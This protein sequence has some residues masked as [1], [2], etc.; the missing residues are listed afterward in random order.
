MQALFIY[1]AARVHLCQLKA[2]KNLLQQS[3]QK[4]YPTIRG[5]LG[6][7]QRIAQ[8][9]VSKTEHLSMV[10]AQ[11]RTHQLPILAPSQFEPSASSTEWLTTVNRTLKANYSE[12]L[13]T[14]IFIFCYKALTLVYLQFVC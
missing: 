5:L 4:I 14:F 10:V 6:Q 7:F 9:Q 12:F 11:V 2:Y 8:L 1:G 3:L 13:F